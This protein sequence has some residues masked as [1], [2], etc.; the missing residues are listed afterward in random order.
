MVRVGDTDLFKVFNIENHAFLSE[1]EYSASNCE[2]MPKTEDLYDCG[3]DES[4]D[5][6]PY[7][8]SV[9]FLGYFQ[10]W[11]Y[12]IR[13]EEDI[14]QQFTFRQHI[15]DHASILL[16]YM[17]SKTNWDYRKDVLVGVHVRRG[18]YSSKKLIEFGQKTAPLRYIKNAIHLMQLIFP[19]SYFLICSD[20]I[21][22]AKTNIGETKNVIFSEGNKPE[23]D[24][25]MLSL[26]NHS[27]ITAGTYSWWVGFL[28]NGVTVYYKD[29][30][31]RNTSYSAQFRDESIADFFPPTWI[32]I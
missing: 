3:Y 18:D 14:R 23:V 12:W 1:D 28:T 22:W 4:I 32:G 11:R 31:T 30:F 15:I 10:S 7:G 25:A 29:I 21:N 9:N 13:H 2:K 19:R 27:I 17:L 5:T 20:T 16:S 6:L 8:K 24:M 26:T